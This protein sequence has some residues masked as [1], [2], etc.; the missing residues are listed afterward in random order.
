LKVCNLIYK[1][2]LDGI[3]AIESGLSTAFHNVESQ[4]KLSSLLA[5]EKAEDTSFRTLVDEVGLRDDGNGAGGLR[6]DF[7][8]ITHDLAVV[9]VDVGR[10]NGED[11]ATRIL[12]IVLHERSN[13]ITER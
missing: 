10:Y 6:V 5:E 12:Q 4:S 9:K 3:A 13:V 1:P 8:C 2:L 7:E 11:N